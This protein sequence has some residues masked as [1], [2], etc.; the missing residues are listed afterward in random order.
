MLKEQY[1]E[2]LPVAPLKIIAMDNC[3]ALGNQIDTG[4]VGFRKQ[5]AKAHEH[6]S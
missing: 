6:F 3:T 5:Y 4:I 2:A 1:L